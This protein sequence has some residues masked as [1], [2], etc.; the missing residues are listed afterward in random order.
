MG[1]IAPTTFWYAALE[2]VRKKVK[3][4]F[5]K[6]PVPS[7]RTKCCVNWTIGCS[8]LLNSNS[9]NKKKSRNVTGLASIS[10]VYCNWIWLIESDL[11]PINK[12]FQHNNNNQ[13]MISSWFITLLIKKMNVSRN[14][15]S[16]ERRRRVS[17]ITTRS[18][19]PGGPLNKKKLPID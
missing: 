6:C 16:A 10:Y 4:I 12:P 8:F 19:E 18:G 3:S 13:N 9:S 2:K 17:T 5:I 14:W 11:V 7:N 15:L 1:K